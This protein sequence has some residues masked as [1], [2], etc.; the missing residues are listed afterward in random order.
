MGRVELVIGDTT[1]RVGSEIG[2][3]ALTRILRVVRLA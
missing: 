1:I 3:A 2:E